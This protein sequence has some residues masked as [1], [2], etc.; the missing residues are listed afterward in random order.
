[1][2]TRWNLP[3]AP[4][5]SSRTATATDGRT[6]PES[7]RLLP[8]V[9]RLGVVCV[10]SAGVTC[11]AMAFDVTPAATARTLPPRRHGT[12]TTHD[13]SI[14][15]VVRATVTHAPPVPRFCRATTSPAPAVESGRMTVPLKTASAP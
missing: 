6:R 15:A 5:R 14:S 2:R 8:A 9:T 1:M 4:S 13:P 7:V 3:S 10:V 11:T 12:R